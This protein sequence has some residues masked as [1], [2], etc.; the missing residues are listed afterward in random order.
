MILQKDTENELN[1]ANNQ[2]GN[3]DKWQHLT[4][5]RKETAEIRWVHNEERELEKL[6]LHR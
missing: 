3:L 6:N 2:R 1:E 5:N 4:R